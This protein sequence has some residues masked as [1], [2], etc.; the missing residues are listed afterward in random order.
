MEF[1][2]S[3]NIVS[4]KKHGT[5]EELKFELHSY[6][7]TPQILKEIRAFKIDQE[8]MAE[9]LHLTKY[10]G[11]FHITKTTEDKFIFSKGEDS[12]MLSKHGW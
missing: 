9:C 11:P 10:F 7:T 1:D 4:V 5:N 12:A 6:G 2:L 3:Q 8:S